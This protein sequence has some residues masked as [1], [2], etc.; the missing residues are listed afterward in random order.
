MNAL[1]WIAAVGCLASVAWMSVE[2]LRAPLIADELD[3]ITDDPRPAQVLQ[4]GQ[5]GVRHG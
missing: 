3:D 2:F 1:A 4:E 5:R